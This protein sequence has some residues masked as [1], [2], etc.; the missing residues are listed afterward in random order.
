VPEQPNPRR[1][2]GDYFALAQTGVEM[3]VPIAL[4]AILDGRLGWTPW[5]T[6]TGAVIGL[7]GGLTHML[8]LLR[9]MD[10]RRN[11]DRGEK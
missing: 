2:V 3:F 5:A 7:V 9:R 1:E 11:A 10:Q 4:G 6:V 8:V